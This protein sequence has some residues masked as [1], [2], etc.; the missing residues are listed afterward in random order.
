MI[1]RNEEIQILLKLISEI[2]K[3]INF[4]YECPTFPQLSK[5]YL[6]FLQAEENLVF[7]REKSFDKVE[8]FSSMKIISIVLTLSYENKPHQR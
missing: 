3:G 5:S 8:L 4:V 7:K 2:F 6:Q 1:H